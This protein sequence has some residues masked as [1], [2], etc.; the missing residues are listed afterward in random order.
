MGFSSVK[1]NHL[2]KIFFILSIGSILRFY[3]L[4]AESI[5]LDE[6]YSISVSK[7]DF[8]QVLTIEDDFPPLYYIVLHGWIKLF[9]DSELS[10][11]F[12][13]MIFGVL[14]IG[15]M[16]KVGALL[17]DQKKGLISAF[18][19][20]LSLFHIHYSQEARPY[21]LTVF[22]ALSSMYG[23]FKC[24]EHWRL[25]TAAG[26]I[27][28]SALLLY[29]H[30]IGLF[31]L[32]AQNFYV[33]TFFLFFRNDMKLRLKYWVAMQFAIGLL[34]LPW[35]PVFFNRVF[36]DIRGAWLAVPGIHEIRS[37]LRKYVGG[38]LFK[39]SPLLVFASLISLNSIQFYSG[40][41]ALVGSL[42]RPKPR[43]IRF[44]IRQHYLILLWVSFPILIP[45]I[46]SQ[47]MTPLYHFRYTIIAAPAFYLLLASGIGNLR[48][49]AVRWL[50][51]GFISITSLLNVFDYF[52]RT[53]KRDW[54][55][56]AKHIQQ[57]ALPDDMLIINH[58]NCRDLVFDYYFDSQDLKRIVS[59]RSLES[60]DNQYLIKWTGQASEHKRV[61]AA[62]TEKSNESD[63][64]SQALGKSHDLIKAVNFKGLRLFL[65]Q[66]RNPDQPVASEGG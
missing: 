51:I 47:F 43:I 11:R 5:W 32:I 50:V 23:F 42:V 8:F 45:F 44:N 31:F 7:L 33:M 38:E 36:D 30:V 24:T 34:F 26:Y 27:L 17:L 58:G 13:S 10:V 37:T 35:L 19:M 2:L 55:G 21:S 46:L 53:T 39:L 15:A 49:A 6:G 16:Y 14:S 63:L 62:I 4:G 18:L 60:V 66:Q 57:F 29:S 65:F 64:I 3:D 9:G 41:S 59:P 12:P 25:T 54:R 20:A 48:P 28:S 22:L 61:W 56:I 52:E 40:C 1:K